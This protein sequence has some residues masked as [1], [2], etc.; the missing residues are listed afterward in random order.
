MRV[1]YIYINFIS[2]SRKKVGYN[3]Q[4]DLFLF[5]AVRSSET[6]IVDLIDHKH[7]VV[8]SGW[9]FVKVIFSPGFHKDSHYQE[10]VYLAAHEHGKY[11]TML[12]KNVVEQ[13]W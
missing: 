1:S 12:W 3:K 5:G 7:N 6:S 8:S 11:H 10:G 13:Q 9:S 4:C 2:L